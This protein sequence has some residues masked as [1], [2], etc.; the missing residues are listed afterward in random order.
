MTPSDHVWLIT[1]QPWIS[2]RN[3]IHGKRFTVVYI[4]IF[5][6]VRFAILSNWWLQSRIGDLFIV[7]MTI[8]DMTLLVTTFYRKLRSLL[9]SIKRLSP[10]FHIC[11]ILGSMWLPCDLN[12]ASTVFHLMTSGDYESLPVDCLIVTF[13]MSDV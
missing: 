10:I 11:L 12:S 13:V 7:D 9:Q 1:W 8:F 6:F 5:I 3:Q 4:F 2:F